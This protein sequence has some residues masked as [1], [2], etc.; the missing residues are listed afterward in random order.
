MEF[1]QELEKYKEIVNK[2]LEKYIIKEECPEQKLNEA[3]EYS[4]IS[5]AK[6][7]RPILMLS[8]YKMLCKEE[9]EEIFPYAVAMEMIHNFSLIH[10]DMPEIDNDDI[11]HRKA[12]KP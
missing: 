4:L 5:S 7:L 8:V 11:R 10:D 12:Y 9:Y 1:K 6:R 2:E 3:K